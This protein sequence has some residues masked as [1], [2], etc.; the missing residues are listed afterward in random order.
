MKYVNTLG[1]LAIVVYLYILVPSLK[2]H[3]HETHDHPH[4]HLDDH[5]WLGK[6]D[7]RLVRCE[8]DVE[9]AHMRISDWHPQK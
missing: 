8:M 9:D 3:S 7:R 1:I 4:Q 2:G 6:L 5:D